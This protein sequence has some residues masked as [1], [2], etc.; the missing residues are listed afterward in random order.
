MNIFIALLLT[1][2]IIGFVDKIAG[3]PLGLGRDFDRGLSSMGTVAVS[4]TGIYCVGI[5]IARQSGAVSQV[6]QGFLPDPSLII[7]CLLAPDMGAT[8]IASA[9]SGSQALGYFSGIVVAGCMGQLI[10]FQLPVLL[11]TLEEK[12][13]SF[14]MKGFLFGLVTVPAGLLAGG[15]VLMLE[16]RELFANIGP[17]AGVCALLGA[18]FFKAGPLLEKLLLFF[19]SAIRAASQL[20]FCVIV[21]EL[22]FP[23]RGILG[24]ELV[25]ESLALVI[26]M[27]LIISGGMVFSSLCQRYLLTPLTWAAK[28]ININEASVIG[29]ILNCINSMAMIPLICEMDERGKQINGAFAVSGA[30]LLGGQ[31]AFIA[32]IG[33]EKVFYAWFLSKLAAGFFA[34]LLVTAVSKS[35]E[36]NKPVVL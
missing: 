4:V 27:T 21:W 32:A 24:R 17:I 13:K 15:M 33:D 29:L 10:S 14:I 22:F 23:G 20:L 35:G 9:L 5:S 25:Y 2:G 36:E 7:G 16:W 12:D 3:S 6:S 30:Y 11:S 19:G 34:V 1:F 8:P 26:K 28:K 18:A 31:M